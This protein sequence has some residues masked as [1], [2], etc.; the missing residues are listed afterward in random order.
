MAPEDEHQDDELKCVQLTPIA[1]EDMPPR[2]RRG[3]P[4]VAIDE[5][6]VRVRE[7][8]L[9]QIWWRGKQWAV[10]DYG[11]ECLDGRYFLEASRLLDGGCPWPLHVGQKKWVDPDEFATAW[12]VALALHNHPA[13]PQDKLLAMFSALK[14]QKAG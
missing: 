2:P 8:E 12:I 3:I 7:G 5:T 1:R 9:G 13:P 11:L 10:T 14:P 4:R 6:P